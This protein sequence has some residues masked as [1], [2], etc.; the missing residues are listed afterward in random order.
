MIQ[1]RLEV[2]DIITGKQP[3]DNNVLN[4]APHPISAIASSEWNRFSVHSNE[5]KTVTDDPPLVLILVKLLSTPCHGLWR[6]SFGQQ[7]PVLTMVCRHSFVPMV[8]ICTN[9]GC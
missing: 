3:K 6:K 2:Q 5:L 9:P 7:F 1:I 8:S 4:N